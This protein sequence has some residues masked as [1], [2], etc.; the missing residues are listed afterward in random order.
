M[1]NSSY[2]SGIVK[3]LE[4]PKQKII[5]NKIIS[6]RFRVLIPQIRKNKF[7]KILSLVFWG[8]FANNLNTF[9]KINDYILIEGYVSIKMNK[10]KDSK[11]FNSKK[12][13]VTVLK[14][15]PFLP[16]SRNL[17]NKF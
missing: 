10:K 5:S 17:I 14:A 1:Q 2:F 12:A 4:D 13:R 16:K 6:I 3:V 9:Y 7:P 11:F 15:Y 8:N